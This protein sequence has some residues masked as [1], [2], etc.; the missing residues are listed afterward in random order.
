MILCGTNELKDYYTSLFV[1]KFDKEKYYVMEN[2]RL[3]SNGDIVI[4]NKPEHT[5][6]EV[7]HSF[8][9]HSIQ[10]E[11][12]EF[13]LYIDS[14]K[15]FDSR[16]FYTAISRARRLE[17]INIV[18]TNEPQFK[19]NGKIYKIVFG[20]E[21]YIGSTIQ[22]ID[23]RFKEHQNGYKKYTEGQGKYITSYK[24]FEKGIPKIS[25][26]EYFKC[27][28]IRQLQE[29]EAEIIQQTKCV[30]KTFNEEK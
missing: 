19:Y 14:S 2:N 4:G 9:T 15:M 21:I 22:S 5:K 8:T 12:A 18:E 28:D 13:N 17:Q 29:R 27:N 3:H 16:M 10:G 20:K 6:C 25:V 7:R 24:L 30:N 1:G 11:T 26:V 23:N